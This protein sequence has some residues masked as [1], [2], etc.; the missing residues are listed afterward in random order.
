MSEILEFLRY[1]MDFPQL[2][3]HALGTT[4][5][6]SDWRRAIVCSFCSIENVY[7]PLVLFLS[8]F[9]IL[10]APT[11]PAAIANNCLPSGLLMSADVR[12]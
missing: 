3:L 2:H 8:R 11:P 6:R 9:A 4:Y 10:G 12:G 7:T 5:A 1:F